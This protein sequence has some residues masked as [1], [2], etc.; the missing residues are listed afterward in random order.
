MTAVRPQAYRIAVIPGDNVGKEVTPE[1]LKVLQSAADC[2]GV[3]L[4]LTSFPWGADHYLAF[5]SVMAPDG[6]ERLAGYDAILFGA[7]GDPARVPDATMSWGLVQKIRKAFDLSVNLRPARLFPGVR[8]A[9]AGL[10][11]LDLVIVRENTEGEYSG[12]GGRLHRGEENEVALQ[13][14]I[15]TRRATERV[16]R[17]A[18]ELARA[19]NLQKKV[20]S[21]TKSNAMNHSMVF[22]DELFAEV[23]RSYP[24]IETEKFHVDAMT[25][26]LIQRP[27]T[28]DVIVASNL[29]GDILSDEAAAIQGG[30][31]LAASA[32][33][34]PGRRFPSMFEPIHGSAPDIAGRQQANPVAAILSAQLM[35]EHLG[36]RATA[37]LIGH[38]VE[39]VLVD[40]TVR[41]RDLG[42]RASTVEMGTAITNAV[43]RLARDSG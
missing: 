41:T 8:S 23:A 22:W 25:M 38:A 34:N 1:A 24:G 18:F 2:T 42:G 30:I 29:F 7:L 20:T 37:E 39:Q 21:V 17:Y 3:K 33:L 11:A 15:F 13:T 9:V 6:L 12:V 28:F 10:D 16:M 19:R 35:F 4:E 36:E 43:E 32:N 5:G 31:G 26:Y 40:G 14:S 27:Q